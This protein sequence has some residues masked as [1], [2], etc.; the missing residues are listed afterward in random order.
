[1]LK[2]YQSA[3]YSWDEP[4]KPHRL[5]VRLLNSDFKKDYNLDIMR[6]FEPV[7]ITKQDEG[8][9]PVEMLVLVQL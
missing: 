9:K 1:V 8:S 5:V 7:T 3:P 6:T 2:G 4:A